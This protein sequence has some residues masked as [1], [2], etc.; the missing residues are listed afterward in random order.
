MTDAGF[1]YMDGLSRL[2]DLRIANARIT[3]SGMSFL[4]DLSELG[5]VILNN[6][7]VTTGGMERFQRKFPQAK[8]GY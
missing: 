6:T 5:S 4:K 2:R 7:P 1:A 3:D 8:L